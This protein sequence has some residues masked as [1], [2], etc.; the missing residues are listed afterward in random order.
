MKS[1][2][3]SASAHDTPVSTPDRRR[4]VLFVDDEPLLTRLG[5]MFLQR[6]GYDVATANCPVN[7]M[8]MFQKESFDA[9]VTDLTMPKMTGIDLARE[10]HQYCPGFPIILTTAFH[11]RLEGQDPVELGFSSLLL[12]PY[13]LEALRNALQHA[14]IQES[15]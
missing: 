9:V 2:V 13:N 4:R 11:H 10:I 15:V 14:W 8:L 6:L 3:K 12:K 5:E 1:V 7:A